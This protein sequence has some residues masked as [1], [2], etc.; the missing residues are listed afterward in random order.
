MIVWKIPPAKYLKQDTNLVF[1]LTN[2][3]II[4]YTSSQVSQTKYKISFKDIAFQHKIVISLWFLWRQ[5][6]IYIWLLMMERDKNY[7]VHTTQQLLFL[8][9]WVFLRA[10][11]IYSG[12][13]TLLFCR[14]NTIRKR[15]SVKSVY[16]W[17]IK[18]NNSLSSNLD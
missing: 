15:L 5:I 12:K 17:H 10:C 4:K 1:D 16:P 18:L 11:Q 3:N 14:N 9:L 2:Y 8:P 7:S 13:F 6:I